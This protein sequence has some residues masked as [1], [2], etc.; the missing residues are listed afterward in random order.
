MYTCIPLKNINFTITD[1]S[2]DENTAIFSFDILRFSRRSISSIRGTNA[3]TA[4][5]RMKEFTSGS[6][7][8]GN[9]PKSLKVS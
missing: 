3:V 4:N 1:V 5:N 9:G 6:L 2:T 7:Y 8:S